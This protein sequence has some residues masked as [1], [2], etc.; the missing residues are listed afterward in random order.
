VSDDVA[1]KESSV[2]DK[3]REAGKH[4]V[5]YGIGSIA[6]SAAGLLLLPILT[7]A[8]SKEDF[9]VYSLII[10]V[11]TIASAIFY[12]GMNSALPRSY[13]DYSAEDDRRAVFTTAFLILLAGS[14]LQIGLGAV[15]GNGIST[16]LFDAARYGSAIFWAL[17]AGALTSING[18]LFS[19]L[20]MLRK[21]VATIVYSLVSLVGSVGLTVLLLQSYPDDLRMPFVAM[22]ITQAAIVAAF[23]VLDGRRAMCLRVLPAEL[24]RLFPYGLASIFASFGGVLLEW[25]D[26]LFIEHYMTLED[27]GDYSAVYRVASLMNVLV[28]LPFTQIWSPMMMEYRQHANI[29]ELFSKVLNYYLLAGACVVSLAA[30]FAGEV[31]DLLIRSGVSS[32]LVW[33]FI[34]LLVAIL[35]SG[36]TNIF[37]AGIFY[38]RK[39]SQLVYVYYG[40]AVVKLGFSGFL[41]AFF[42]LTGAAVSA[43]IAFLILPTAIHFMSRNYFSFP[44]QWTVLIRI[45]LTMTAIV[46]GSLMLHSFMDVSLFVQLLLS[47]L[48]LAALLVVALTAAERERLLNTTA[49]AFR[50]ISTR[51]N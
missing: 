16:L 50:A 11:S 26:R 40:T 21:S 20:R 46:I 38:E 22:A 17:L 48:A 9:G 14:A 34:L 35:F 1:H 51:A 18:L 32:E 2:R 12:L 42:G 15:G 33:V 43:I 28:I 8:L 30:L 39:L 29:K 27:V 24:P 41:V 47:V 36:T 45:T 13:Y 3:L 7:G 4:S 49:L 5:I 19:Y 10:M 31:L 6:Q 37:V 25:M 44:I 23:L